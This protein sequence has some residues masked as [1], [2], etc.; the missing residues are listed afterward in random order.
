MVITQGHCVA[1]YH[2]SIG[3]TVGSSFWYAPWTK[4]GKLCEHVLYVD[5][6]DVHLTIPEVIQDDTWVLGHLYT[7]LP[8][9]VA[10][11]ICGTPMCFNDQIQDGFT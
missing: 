5:I 11:A 3:I 10:E 1:I 4:F 8:S 9:P 2:E 6:H 7:Q